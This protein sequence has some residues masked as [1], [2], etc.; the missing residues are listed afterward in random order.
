MFLSENKPYNQNNTPTSIAS[1]YL[2]F[3]IKCQGLQDS[4]ALKPAESNIKHSPE[5]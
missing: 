4:P 5:A 1:K 3:M 2:D